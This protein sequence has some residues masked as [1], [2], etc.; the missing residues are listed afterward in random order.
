[1]TPLVS[2][3]QKRTVAE[4]WAY[5]FNSL[6]RSVQP[7]FSS[8][9]DRQFTYNV[10]LKRVLVAIVVVKKAVSIKYYGCVSLALVIQL[11]KRMRH[12]LVCGLSGCTI[13]LHIIS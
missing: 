3:G 13:F 1:M 4:A 9:Q 11:A 2:R 8:Q 5:V 10:K 7:T 6:K 12:I